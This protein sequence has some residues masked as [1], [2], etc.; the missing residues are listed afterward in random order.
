MKKENK[1][2]ARLGFFVIISAL[3]FMLGF[4][5]IGNNQNLFGKSFH[6]TSTF[7]NVNGLKK[8]NVVRFNGIDVG[9]I[10]T[11]DFVDDSTL[12]VEMRIENKVRPFIKKN[13]LASI[14]SEGLVGNMLV[15]I[16]PGGENMPSVEDGD[17]IKSF[18]RIET[19]ELLST[20]GNTSENVAIISKNLLDISDKMNSGQGV[21]ANLL[22]DEGM[23]RDLSGT[24]HQLH[25]MVNLLDKTSGNINDLFGKVKE[26]QGLLGEL[27]SD[28]VIVATLR[29]ST[30]QLDTTLS[31]LHQLIQD[32]DPVIGN[33][34]STSIYLKQAAGR[35]DTLLISIDHGD[36]TVTALLHD[37][38]LR[39]DLQETLHYLREGTERF[40]EDMEALKQNVFFRKYFRQKEKE[41]NHPD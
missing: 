17:E 40:S 23:S 38:Q 28:T 26:G 8:G 31:S 24:I 29:K 1:H 41:I 4:Y 32:A 11:I 19:E 13:A 9:T 21:L 14:G 6:L 5:L 33:L 16:S 35:L 22:N 20:L 3:L 18:S 36:G 15:N 25:Q 30:G 2:V 7:Q 34:N 27:I 37:P 39:I 10:S 12:Q